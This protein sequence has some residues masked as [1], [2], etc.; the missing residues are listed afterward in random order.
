MNTRLFR[1]GLDELRIPA[2]DG[3]IRQVETYVD[4]LERWNRR[5]NLVKATGDVLIVRHVLD[6][7]AGFPAIRELIPSRLVDVG[8]GAGLPGILL[9]IFLRGSEVTLL[10]RSAKRVSFLKNAVALL[11]MA[12]C[13]VV[14]AEVERGESVFDVVCCRAFKPLAD[15]FSVLASRLEP[16][17]SLVFYKGKK[18]VVLDELR[19][20]GEKA[21]GY[22]TTI[23]P[24]TV[25]FL[26]EERHLLLFRDTSR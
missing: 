4:E 26:S 10:E 21:A 12:G 17:G 19:S 18:R 6:C 8:S 2:D 7:L 20:L 23:L 13:S 3:Q 16:G 1:E 15:S 9:A 25:P 5:M 24:V 14:E 11:N 22:E